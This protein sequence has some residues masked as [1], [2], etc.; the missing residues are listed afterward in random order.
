MYIARLLFLTLFFSVT[1]LPIVRG[2]D[3]PVQQKTLRAFERSYSLEKEKR[4][5]EAMNA[6]QTLN[7]P[8]EYPVNLRLGWL[9]H[10]AGQYAQAVDYY[11]VAQKLQPKSTEPLWGLLLPL[12]AQE[13]WIEAEKVYL[14]ILELDPKNSSANYQLGLIYYYR[15]DYAQARKFLDV[16]LE[17]SPFD[18]YFMLMGAW[19]RLFLGQTDEATHLFNRVLLN[20]PYDQSAQEGLARIR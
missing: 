14:S 11:K 13:N 10:H 1:A 3:D 8:N 17:L 7:Q 18:Y 9:A 6:L 2:G 5:T 15:E 20:T 12:N 16:S 19:T 4:Y